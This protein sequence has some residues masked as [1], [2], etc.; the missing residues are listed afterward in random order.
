MSKINFGDN[1]WLIYL[2]GTPFKKSQ[3]HLCRGVSCLLSCLFCLHVPWRLTA[4]G[5]REVKE[6]QPKAKQWVWSFEKERKLARNAK[7]LPYSV[8]I[9][10]SPHFEVKIVLQGISEPTSRNVISN[11]HFSLLLSKLPRN[12]RGFF[13]KCLLWV[14]NQIFAIHAAQKQQ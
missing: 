7:K 4:I 9:L 14:W 11:Y 1:H 13:L 6:W 12:H 10:I 8:F 2:S 3:V 5:P